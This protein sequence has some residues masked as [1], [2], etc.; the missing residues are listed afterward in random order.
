MEKMPI[1]I[2]L[3]EYG[4]D[5]DLEGLSFNEVLKKAESEGYITSEGK[6]NSRKSLFHQFVEVYDVPVEEIRRSGRHRENF[7]K[8]YGEIKYVLKT[9]YYY[10]LIEYRELEEAR[11]ASSRA[12]RNAKIAI[13]ISVFALVVSAILG[14]L[15]ITNTINLNDA[16][17]KEL[18]T[19]ITKAIDDSTSSVESKADSIVRAVRDSSNSVIRID[20]PQ[21]ERLEKA[22][23]LGRPAADDIE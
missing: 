1:F 16:Q 8:A 18:T 2:R 6:D 17:L 15:Q 11:I 4:E 12:N 21:I 13:G 7:T 10:R 20:E 3:L 22:I 9:E 14:F 5:A 23:Q 19:S